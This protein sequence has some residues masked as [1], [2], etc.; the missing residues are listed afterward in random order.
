MGW[1]DADFDDDDDHDADFDDDDD[2]D[3]YVEDDDDDDFDDDDDVQCYRCVQMLLTCIHSHSSLLLTV[4][5]QHFL[6]FL[7]F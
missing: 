6:L 2:D 3:D 7:A 4:Q 1:D 5:I